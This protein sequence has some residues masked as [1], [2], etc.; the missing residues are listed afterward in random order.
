MALTCA[1]CLLVFFVLATSGQDALASAAKA[2]AWQVSDQ[3]KEKKESEMLEAL[4]DREVDKCHGK[5][6]FHS[7]ECCK[8]SA[9][10]DI[11]GA[12]GRCLPIHNKVFYQSCEKDSDCGAGLACL[13]SGNFPR[14]KTCQ[15][16]G[17]TIEKKG[18]N[19][20]CVTSSECD[21]DRGLCCQVLRRH[22]MASKKLCYYFL[23]PKSC[24]GDVKT[25]LQ[26]LT[27]IPNPFFKARL[28][29]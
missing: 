1:A 2:E 27:Y 22:R 5:K 10:V 28:G 9:C 7:E 26:E 29:K 16:E 21:T 11:E 3:M 13:D 4:L 23:D 17:G 6:C 24:V 12:S 20:E 18:F 19:D 25:S 14:F 15:L 8:G